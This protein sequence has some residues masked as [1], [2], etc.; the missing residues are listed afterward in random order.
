[1]WFQ[2]VAG[3]RVPESSVK[4]SSKTEAPTWGE[5]SGFIEA[6]VVVVLCSFFPFPVIDAISC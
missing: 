2:L 4:V 1:M 6:A 3:P 5:Y